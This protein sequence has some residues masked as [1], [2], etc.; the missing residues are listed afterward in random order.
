MTRQMIPNR[1]AGFTDSDGMNKERVI[2]SLTHS[3]DSVPVID[4][5]LWKQ[6]RI[7]AI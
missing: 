2:H 1:I 4:L 3:H 5:L 6:E 7:G